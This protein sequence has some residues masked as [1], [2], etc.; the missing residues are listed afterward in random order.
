MDST[1]EAVLID[2]SDPSTVLAIS[3]PPDRTPRTRA[4][5]TA[6]GFELGLG[7]AAV[8]LALLLGVELTPMLR[9]SANDISIGFAAIGPMLILFLICLYVEIEPLR[10]IRN[11]LD[12]QLPWLLGSCGWLDLV[13]ISFAA[14]IG[15]ELFF[16]GLLQTK[17]AFWFG[18]T[19]ALLI[20][21]AV[22]GLAHS[23]T[24]TYSILTALIGLYL[25]WLM[26]LTDGLAAPIIA[27]G[28]Y[29]LFALGYLLKWR[30][31]RQ[32]P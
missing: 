2:D 15:E 12:E 10:A 13:W 14:G 20:A 21:S 18:V 32:H 26:V 8:V 3:R 27:H 6:L 30:H 24:A 17:L 9:T 28:F 25:G 11:L 22:F 16:R 4:L 5:W 29:D 7:V 31:L 1:D 19:P 23:I